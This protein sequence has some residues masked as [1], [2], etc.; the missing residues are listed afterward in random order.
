MMG[1][2]VAQGALFYDFRLDDHLPANHPLRRTDGLLDF[3]FV[4]EAL[5]LATARADGRRLI[6]SLCSECC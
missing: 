1:R 5:R 6:Q 2:Q 4:R 3:G